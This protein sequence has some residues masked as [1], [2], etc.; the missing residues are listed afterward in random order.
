MGAVCAVLPRGA[1][2]LLYR[3]LYLFCAVWF[4]PFGQG[5]ESCCA[6]LTD[7][8]PVC[9]HGFVQGGRC[10]ADGE[11][12]PFFRCGTAFFC[13]T[14]DFC[15]E[16]FICIDETPFSGQFVCCDE[17]FGDDEII[18]VSGLFKDEPF[19]FAAVIDIVFQF[20]DISEAGMIFAVF[21]P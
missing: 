10:A 14:D 3:Y 13:V 16:L 5:V 17:I 18:F 11:S 19:K 15:P 6:V 1:A 8:D 7:G 9:D 12:D 4:P 20:S 21:S 2:P